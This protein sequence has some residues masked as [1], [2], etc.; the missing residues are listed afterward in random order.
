MA[1]LNFTLTQ[2]EYMLAV[3]QYGHFA[4]A[5]EACFVTQ[6]TL[7]MQL[8]K[9]E[10]SLGVTLFDRSKKPIRLTLEGE[11]ILECVKST[12]SEAKKIESSLKKLNSSELEGELRI[13]VIPTIAP[14]LLPKALK[15]IFDKLPKLE[16]RIFELQTSQILEKIKT[17]NLDAGIMAVPILDHPIQQIHLYY[18][19][20]HVYCGKKH[21][22]AALKKI[23]PKKLTTEDIWLLEEGHCLRTQVLE[24]CSSV[25]H[26][27]SDRKL[28]FESG[29]LDMISELIHSVGGYTLIPSM[30]KESLSHRGV[31]VPITTPAPS[32]E[33]GIVFSRQHYKFRLIQAFSGTLIESLPSEIKSLA[34]KKLNLIPVELED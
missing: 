29:N 7:S 9:L 26:K 15:V 31:I 1:K 18:E 4:K 19:P 23:D 20:F 2:L 10:E 27:K 5:A 32:R 34:T 17:D 25:K 12:L 24:I 11:A 3:H 14:Y 13:G 28:Q 6:P 33:V 8:Q 16:L 30:A 21:P 22:F